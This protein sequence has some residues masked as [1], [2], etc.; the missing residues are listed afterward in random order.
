MTLSISMASGW[1]FQKGPKHMSRFVPQAASL[2]P[3]NMFPLHV[4][5]AV[6][7]ERLPL[8][9]RHTM[10][11][12][13]VG[14]SPDG[15]RGMASPGRKEAGHGESPGAVPWIQPCSGNPEP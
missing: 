10:L 5:A 2:P 7:S 12:R 9:P 3:P 11:H 13:S 14:D 8:I 6:T 15:C 4:A 1:S